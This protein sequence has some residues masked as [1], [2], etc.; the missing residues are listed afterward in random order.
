MIGQLLVAPPTQD[1]EPWERSVIFIYEESHSGTIGLITNKPSDRT[2]AEVAETQG[3]HYTDDDVIYLG[4]PVNS[5][6]LLMLHSDEWC[7]SNTMYIAPGFAISSDRQMLHRLAAGDRPRRWKM[8]LGMSAWS[9]AQLEGEMIGD[10]PWDK[11]KAWITAPA[12]QNIVFADKPDLAWKRS[13]NLAA[14]EMVESY[15]TI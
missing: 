14:K 10:A 12:T 13:I 9:S 3:V 11:R 8:F 5:G 4:G 15:F 6:A 1:N 7:C 2:L